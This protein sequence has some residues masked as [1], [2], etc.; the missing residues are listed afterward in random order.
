[1]PQH[2]KAHAEASS[3]TP[4]PVVRKG[5]PRPSPASI[6]TTCTP[7]GRHR[8]A[9]L[10]KVNYPKAETARRD[11]SPRRRHHALDASGHPP[12][13][14]E[15]GA[16]IETATG[17]A[18][19]YDIAS[20]SPRVK[21]FGGGPATTC[22]VTRVEMFVGF[23]QFAY[24]QGRAGAG[25]PGIGLQVRAAPFVANTTGSV[26]ERAAP[27]VKPRP[28]A[29]VDSGSRRAQSRVVEPAEPGF[30]PTRKKSR[31]PGGF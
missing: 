16:N 7:T 19:A 30:T 21:E 11:P 18:A 13:T 17:V 2:L 26:S 23:E 31:T 22:P 5:E 9:G 10:S 29:S 28:P 8:L 27:S 1:V 14:V 6:T 20:A 3:R 24:G 4:I 15:I 25:G 12:G